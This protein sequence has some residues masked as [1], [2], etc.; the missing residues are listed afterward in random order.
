MTTNTKT[1]CTRVTPSLTSQQSSIYLSHANTQQRTRAK[2]GTT[3]QTRQ[4]VP[5]KKRSPDHLGHDTHADKTRAACGQQ[6]DG[7][8]L[9][10]YLSL[11]NLKLGFSSLGLLELEEL[12]ESRGSRERLARFRFLFVFDRLILRALVVILGSLTKDTTAGGT[13]GV[14]PTEKKA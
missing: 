9:P 11:R 14:K 12:L 2:L 7:A 6:E 13:N 3:I 10:L 8:N 4:T 1:Q 5:K